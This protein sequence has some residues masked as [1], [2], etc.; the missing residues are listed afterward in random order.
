MR[1]RKQVYELL[2]KDFEG[3]KLW[4]VDAGK[5]EHIWGN[6]SSPVLYGD[7]AILWVGPGE[8]HRLLAFNL[9]GTFLRSFGGEDAGSAPGEFRFP[10][11]VEVD[12]KGNLL[13][14]EFGNHRVQKID[15]DTGEALAI[16]GGSFGGRP[17]QVG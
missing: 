7:L 4:S 12:E 3:K 6:A 15:P 14:S 16:W 9:D 2:P 13:V 11:G 5:M 1:I 10:Y 17:G 8:N